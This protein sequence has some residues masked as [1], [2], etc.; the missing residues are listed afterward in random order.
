MPDR[1]EGVDF[2][3]W[4]VPLLPVLFAAMGWLIT[5]ISD[6]EKQLLE[7][8]GSLMLL[9]S[10]QGTIIPSPDNALARQ[11][12]REDMLEYVHDLQVRV[13]LLEEHEVHK[14]AGH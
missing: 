5:T 6:L 9:V 1:R 7:V 2:S 11:R 4:V 8:R 13:K 12:L 10:P 3:K 14:K